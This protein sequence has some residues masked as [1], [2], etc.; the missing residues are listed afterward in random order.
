M[1][2]SLTLIV[3]LNLP[4]RGY[5]SQPL[6]MDCVRYNTRTT[7]LLKRPVIIIGGART[8]YY[9]TSMV[10]DLWIP[11]LGCCSPLLMLC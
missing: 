5:R 3:S 2:E 11:L 4:P 6:K 1:K 7:A 10:C 8:R 9:D